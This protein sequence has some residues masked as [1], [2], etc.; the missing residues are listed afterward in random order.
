ME[1]EDK[2]TSWKTA[3]YEQ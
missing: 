1:K 3:P 2:Q